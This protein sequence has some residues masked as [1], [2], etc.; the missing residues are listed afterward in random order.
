VRRRR[1]VILSALAH[2]PFAPRGIRTREL[3]RAL[4]ER[5]DVE[6]I[7]A[8][9][10]PDGPSRVRPRR[11]PAV[12][13]HLADGVALDRYEPWSVRTLLRWSPQADAALL[14]G[15]PFSPH[16]YAVPRLAAAGIPYAVDMGDPWV[17]TELAPDT[18]ALALLRAR[19]HERRMWTRAAGAILTTEHQ[20]NSLLRLFPALR[21]LVRANGFDPATVGAAPAAARVTGRTL[22]L[23]HFGTIYQARVPVVPFLAALADDGPWERVELHQYGTVVPTAPDCDPRVGVVLHDPLP[24]GHAVAEAAGYDAA[25][26]I[27]NVDSR[28]LPSKAVDYLTLPVPRVALTPDPDGDALGRYVRDRP[29]W[30]TVSPGERDAP[31]R[32]AAHVTRAWSQDDLAAPSSEAWPAVASR[33]ADFLDDVLADDRSRAGQVVAA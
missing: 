8:P 9:P 16:A 2:A 14:V 23:A 3:L 27:G 4:E 7:A 18:T 29:G 26:V 15:Y 20:R 32:L 10:P 25:I 19:R 22:R 6:L 11:F 17:L 28:V 12:V 31:G 33:V 21:V 1:L 5:W 30:L 13:G 24:W